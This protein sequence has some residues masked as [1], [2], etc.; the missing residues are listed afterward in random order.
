M[1][2]VEHFSVWSFTCGSYFLC[3][4]M[5]PQEFWRAFTNKSHSFKY[6]STLRMLSMSYTLKY[7]NWT[8]KCSILIKI[9]PHYLEQSFI[10]YTAIVRLRSTSRNP[11]LIPKF[12]TY[13]HF[14]FKCIVPCKHVI[15]ESWRN[16]MSQV[17]RT[18]SANVIRSIYSHAGEN[19]EVSVLWGLK[20]MDFLL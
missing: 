1:L 12:I 7:T 15:S 18:T 4:L 16:P 19:Q 2:S 9:M 13:F 20:L 11:T 10:Q 3:I 17:K 5:I 8:R 14:L 6:H